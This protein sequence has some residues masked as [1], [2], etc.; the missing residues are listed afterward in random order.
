VVGESVKQ[1]AGDPLPSSS[2]IFDGRVVR[3]RAA[4]GEVLGV[5]VLRAAA[6]PLAV[7]LEIDGAAVRAWRVDDVH[8]TRPST[9]MY[10]PSRGAG[11]YPDVLV[12]GQ[13]GAVDAGRDALFDV[14]VARDAAAGVHAGA[15]RVG[16]DT[17]AV[18]LDVA[19]VLLP[20]IDEHPRVWAYYNPRELARARLDEAAT[21]ALFRADGVLASPELTPA[22]A[23]ARAAQV[24]GARFVPVLLPSSRDEIV[25]DAKTWAAWAARTGQ[26]PF[27]IPVDEPHSITAKLEA[28]TIA[29]WLHAAGGG[30][31]LAVTDAPEWL[32]GGD[33]DVFVSPG[34]PGTGPAE[35][36]WTYNGAPP[37][38]GAMIAD[39][40]GVALRT[41][42]WIGFVHDVPLWYVWDAAYWR[43]RHNAARRGGS[44]ETAPTFDPA[45]DAATYDD[46][47]DVG[48]LDGVLVYPDGAPSLRLAALRR[49]IEDR[50]LLDELA[51]CAGRPRALA[52]ARALVPRSLGELGDAPAGAGEWPVDEAPWEAA[53]REVLEALVACRAR[54]M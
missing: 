51:A 42:G 36:R 20:P 28:R 6:E 10:G 15:L 54:G 26:Q 49:G 12:A 44:R 33:V 14:A 16:G 39:T 34:A 45:Q 41:W 43:D 37:R 17:F 11:D 38:S 2:P 46:G 19:P 7:S 5:Q 29:R 18:E 4:R 32:Y 1:R 40:D 27:A 23:D 25:R 53:R 13:G 31:W 48:N 30:V 21:A 35:R 8:V 22:D 47:E 52:I 3:L 24:R 50:A 9:E